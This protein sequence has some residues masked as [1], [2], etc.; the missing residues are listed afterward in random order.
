M[1]FPLVASL[2]GLFL[3]GNPRVSASSERR[4]FLPFS[5]GLSMP[6]RH[7]FPPF[8]LLMITS[9]GAWF[10]VVY[11]ECVTA[12]TAWMVSCVG[13]LEPSAGHAGAIQLCAVQR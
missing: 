11:V 10:G 8:L 6:L 4:D 5:A 9:L 3:V 7:L 12:R 2:Q 1:T 13:Q